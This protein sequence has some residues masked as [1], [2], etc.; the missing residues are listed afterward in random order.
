MK[1]GNVERRNATI[2]VVEELS[3]GVTL[4]PEED[5]LEAEVKSIVLSSIVPGDAPMPRRVW[6]RLAYVL[7][8]IQVANTKFPP[9]TERAIQKEFFDY[10]WEQPLSSIAAHLDP[11]NY[12]MRVE[13]EALAE[14]LNTSNRAHSAEMTSFEGVLADE[15]GGVAELAEPVLRQVI[16]RLQGSDI[17]SAANRSADRIGLNLLRAILLGEQAHRLPTLHVH[18][19]LHSLF[20]WEYRDKLITG[21]DMFDVAHATAALAYCDAFFAERE[22]AKS[23]THRRL[24]LDKRHGCFVTNNIAEAISYLKALT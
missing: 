20:R 21:N 2:D 13:M 1:V 16:G 9:E 4:M 3:A 24:A 15:M 5:R 17:T 18:A 6:T 7:G 8:N 19:S 10:L 14:R 11:K 23:V 12:D 22:L